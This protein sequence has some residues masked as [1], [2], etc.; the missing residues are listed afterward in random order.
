MKEI[1]AS[2]ADLHMR[3]YHGSSKRPGCLGGVA[4]KKE[5]TEKSLVDHPPHYNTGKYETIDVIEDWDLDFNCGNAVKYISRH[6]HKGKPIRDI[7]KAIWYLERRLKTLKE[8]S[9]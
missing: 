9:N 6:M 7:E 3:D 4:A 1:V 5:T 8:T 2:V